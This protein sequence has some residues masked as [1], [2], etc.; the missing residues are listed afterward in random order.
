MAPGILTEEAQPAL[1]MSTAGKGTPSEDMYGR[2]YPVDPKDLELES[3]FGPMRPEQMGYLQPT[4]ADTPIEEMRKRF[5]K[6]GYLL[7]SRI[8]FSFPSLGDRQDD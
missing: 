8:R 6:D 7:V 5:S 1:A 3:N 2:Y 4:S